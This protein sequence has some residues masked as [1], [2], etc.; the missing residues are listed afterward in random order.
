MNHFLLSQ[1]NQVLS[2]SLKFLRHLQGTF[3]ASFEWC[4][5]CITPSGIF[6]FFFLGYGWMIS[7]KMV[8]L[9]LVIHITIV[10][11]K[12]VKASENYKVSRDTW[13]ERRGRRWNEAADARRN[14]GE[15][16]SKSRV[17][18][19]PAKASHASQVNT[20]LTEEREREKLAKSKTKQKARTGERGGHKNTYTSGRLF[21][22]SPAFWEDPGFYF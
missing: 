5:V 1:S 10:F 16:P 22:I 20:S 3:C 9:M 11:L 17:V 15:N 6:F 12:P 13:P 8:H 14:C 7:V 19:A 2:L 18:R 21:V 4:V